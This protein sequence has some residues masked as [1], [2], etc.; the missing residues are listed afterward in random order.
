[1]IEINQKLCAFNIRA[2]HKKI[3]DFERNQMWLQLQ[4]YDYKF[5][6]KKQKN[7]QLVLAAKLVGVALTEVKQYHETSPLKLIRERTVR[8]NS[9]DCSWIKKKWS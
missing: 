5:D 2:R 6:N 1:M 9:S 7:I 8:N 4:Y 3:Y